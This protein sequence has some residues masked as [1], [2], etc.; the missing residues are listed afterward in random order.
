MLLMGAMLAATVV[1]SAS[2]HPCIYTSGQN[3]GNCDDTLKPHYH[4]EWADPL[5]PECVTGV[6][7][8]IGTGF[9]IVHFDSVIDQFLANLGY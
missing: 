9:V 1:P 6:D 5:L 8:I 7:D 2:A 3:C 4:A